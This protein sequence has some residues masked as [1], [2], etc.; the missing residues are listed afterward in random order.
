[1]MNLINMTK[2]LC[3]TSFGVILRHPR[4]SD[5]PNRSKISRD[6]IDKYKETYKRVSKLEKTN[7]ATECGQYLK[8]LDSGVVSDAISCAL[9][10]RPLLLFPATTGVGIPSYNFFI[11]VTLGYY[12]A[13]GRE[14]NI[15][16]MD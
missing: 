4:C 3:G 5:G 10:T 11:F 7:I 2:N 14:E 9:R 8:E 6:L 15:S 16:S 12:S 13:L 1:M